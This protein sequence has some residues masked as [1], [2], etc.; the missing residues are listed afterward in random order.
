MVRKVREGKVYKVSK[1]KVYLNTVF[2]SGN[3]N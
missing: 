1:V 3:Y 2:P